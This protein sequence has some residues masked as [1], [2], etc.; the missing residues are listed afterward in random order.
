MLNID[1]SNYCIL[2]GVVNNKIRNADTQYA[3]RPVV[4]IEFLQTELDTQFHTIAVVFPGGIISKATNG[5]HIGDNILVIGKLRTDNEGSVY[6]EADQFRKI[7][8]SKFPNLA[9]G[10][11]YYLQ[12]ANKINF[13]SIY[14]KIERMKDNTLLLKCN[15]HDSG[16]C[17]FLEQDMIQFRFTKIPEDKLKEDMIISI[18]GCISSVDASTILVEK[19]AFLC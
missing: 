16:I 12:E 3:K 19:V 8:E 5:I 11:A 6:L 18:N 1:Y 2:L 14:G 7:N 4:D 17:D 10:K 13:F 15:R 9:T